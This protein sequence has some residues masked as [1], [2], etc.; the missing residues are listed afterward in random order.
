MAASEFMSSN[1]NLDG[2]KFLASISKT[3]NTQE[4]SK[5]DNAYSQEYNAADH[6]SQAK[7]HKERARVRRLDSPDDHSRRHH[8]HHRHRHSHKHDADS[9]SDRRLRGREKP[10]HLHKK[11]RKSSESEAKEKKITAH[12]S[13]DESENE[14][15]WVVPSPPHTPSTTNAFI[16]TNGDSDSDDSVIVGPT[17]PPSHV[18]D[19]K[20]PTLPTVSD[21]QLQNTDLLDSSLDQM[22]AARL[23]SMEAAESSLTGAVDNLLQGGFN[24]PTSGP[25]DR[26]LE[27][28]KMENEQRKEFARAKSPGG[29][30]E[31]GDDELFE[32]DVGSAGTKEKLNE[33]SQRKA[34][35]ERIKREQRE[36]KFRERDAARRERWEDMRA[37]E[38]K[39]MQMLKELARERFGG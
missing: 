21:I 33:I 31:F 34:E 14:G 8:H 10:T 19:R 1:S 36:A 32:G 18:S 38:D 35:K 7:N 17:L 28:R 26:R 15:E 23:K 30:D 37:K 22:R 3:L 13:S 2:E 6:K 25:R 24:D 20:G 5:S 4:T 12:K 16:S 11:R 29:V 9:A 27:K 39:T